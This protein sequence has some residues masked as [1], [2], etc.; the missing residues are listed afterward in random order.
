LLGSAAST[1]DRAFV[2]ALQLRSR[3]KR[4]IAESLPHAERMAS[5]ARIERTYAAPEHF[6]DPEAFFPRPAQV[7]PALRRVRDLPWGGECLEL[8]W[9]SAFEPFDARVGTRYLA[10]VPNR[11]AHA[12]IYAGHAGHGGPTGAGRPAVI[13]VHGY[14]GGHWAF[15]ERAW[16]IRSLNR[17]GLDVATAVLPFHALRA[18]PGEGAPPFPAGDPRVTNE[19]FRQTVADLR[20]LIAIL[21]QRGASSVGIMGMSL[22][23]YSTALMATLEADLSFAAPIIPLASVADYARDHG[24]LGSGNLG[25]GDDATLQHAALEAANRVVSPF[26]RPALIPKE[27]LLIIAGEDD[28]VTPIAHAERLA[29]HFGVPLLRLHGGHIVQ[30]WRATGFRALHDLLRRSGLTG[31]WTPTA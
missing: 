20:S 13:A 7:T 17:W 18:R 27:R 4:A 19:G 25:S 10:H 2:G 11:T 15:E 14:M 6:T 12:R 26:A 16:P 21:R 3:G 23:G 29:E 24:H 1:V 8:S 28:R 5:L 22:G 31:A 9:P 30:T